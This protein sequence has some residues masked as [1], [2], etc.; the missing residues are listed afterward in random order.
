[1]ICGF[2]EITSNVYKFYSSNIYVVW[3]LKFG[4]RQQDDIA[5]KYLMNSRVVVLC[6]WNSL[7]VRRQMDRSPLPV[8]WCTPG[9]GTWVYN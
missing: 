5:Y 3:I 8:S 2:F 4:K 7:S 9:Q 6:H 1:M